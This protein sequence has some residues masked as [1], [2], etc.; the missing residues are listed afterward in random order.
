M[1][2]P[3]DD[4]EI[5]FF[6]ETSKRNRT[7][8]AFFG[9]YAGNGLRIGGEFDTHTDDGSGTIQQIM[10]AYASYRLSDKIEG[11]IYVDMYDPDTSTENDGNT[12]MIIGFNY[13]PEK[14]L[15]MTPN[16]RISTPEEGDSTTMFMLNFEFKF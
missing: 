12:D 8:M 2:V 7:L 4:G 15:T 3:S 11:L 10:A 5:V 9:G 14:G 13:K 6:P 16:I 1:N